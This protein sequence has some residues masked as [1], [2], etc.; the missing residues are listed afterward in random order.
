MPAAHVPAAGVPSEPLAAPP[1][2]RAERLPT[3]L[4]GFRSTGWW[5]MILLI[6]NEAILFASLIASYFYL[7]FNNPVWPFDGIKRPE[8]LL[9]AIA[10][11]VLLSSSV[12]MHLG[13]SGIKSDNRGRLQLM[14]AIAFILGAIFLGIQVYEYARSEF[15]PQANVYGS[16]FFAITGI[17]GLHVLGGLLLNGVIQ[18]RTALGHFNARR[19]LGVEN[20]TMYWHFVDVVWIVV[21]T[22]L[23]LSTY[24]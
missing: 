2:A 12:F 15:A 24:L 11:V 19:Y 16:L 6:A 21:F 22:S 5:G 1:G 7:R 20:V 18:V 14:L 10:T 13:E 4:A 9:P 17:H 3:D 8:L 23:Y